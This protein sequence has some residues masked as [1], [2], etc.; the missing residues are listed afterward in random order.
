M[1]STVSIGLSHMNSTMAFSQPPSPLKRGFPTFHYKTSS[2]CCLPTFLLKNSKPP[3][4]DTH[5]FH[6]TCHSV[7][8]PLLQGLEGGQE[9][10][11][12]VSLRPNFQKRRT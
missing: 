4:K 5:Y 2:F 12:V 6:L 7:H 3:A 9:C 8:L 1:Y 11:E 10:L